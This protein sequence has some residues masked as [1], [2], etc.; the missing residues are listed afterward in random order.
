MRKS[1]VEL[2]TEG[3]AAD[4]AVTLICSLEDIL[5][6]THAAARAA[7]HET[8]EQVLAFH[9][10]MDT[11]LELAVCIADRLSDG[12]LTLNM[13]AKRGAW[14]PGHEEA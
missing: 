4:A 2:M 13:E 10:A 1:L 6:I 5:H 7:A 9:A 12:V 8:P 11:M 3:D 14:R